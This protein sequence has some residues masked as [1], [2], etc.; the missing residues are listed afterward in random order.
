MIEAEAERYGVAGSIIKSP[1]NQSA[2][3]FFILLHPI[4]HEALIILLMNL[5]LSGRLPSVLAHAGVDQSQ[6]VQKSHLVRRSCWCYH[7]II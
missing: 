4:L 2:A 1:K 3:Y 6:S 5:S 7:N